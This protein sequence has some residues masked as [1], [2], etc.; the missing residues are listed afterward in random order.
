LLAELH[1]ER[2]QE[3]MPR[4]SKGQVRWSTTFDGDNA[5]IHQQVKRKEY[6][7]WERRP[8]M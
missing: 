4:S 7:L 3:G 6:A 1:K 2:Q 5:T 8:V